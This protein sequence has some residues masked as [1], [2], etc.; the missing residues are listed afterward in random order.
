[1]FIMGVFLFPV[2]INAAGVVPPTVQASISGEILRVEVRN[3][4]FDVEA[5]FINDKRFNFRVDSVLQADLLT[6][7]DSETVTVYAIDFEGNR[8]NTIM[9]N[10]PY[11]AIPYV[12][13]SIPV[14][15]SNPFTPNGQA[16]VTDNAF[17]GDEK[18]FF[19]FT[20]PDGNVFFLIVD[21][22][23]DSDNVYFLNAVTEQDLISLAAQSG[24]PITV[25]TNS[26]IPVVPTPAPPEEETQAE[27]ADPDPPKRN[28]N[29]G[30]MIF[31]LIVF[32]VAGGVGY[33]VK[34]VR[35]KQQA[36]DDDY[37]NENE[38]DL[39]EEMKFADE[40]NNAE[41]ETEDD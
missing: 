10:N 28:G 6:F 27:E 41:T 33:Y 22:Q 37:A 19:T 39:G 21:R 15:P 40:T 18:E 17:D 29:N 9:L 14:R 7:E 26:G 36:G 5:V 23:R 24:N 4:T 34:I 30:N 11:Y 12:P 35:P 3:G 13:Q 2:N 20:T 1:M 8:S 38:E 31:L 25:S 32:V 16:N